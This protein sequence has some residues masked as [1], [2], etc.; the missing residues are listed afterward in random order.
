MKRKRAGRITE[1]TARFKLH[2]A[3]S[4]ISKQQYFFVGHCESNTGQ[5]YIARNLAVSAQQRTQAHFQILGVI[6][7]KIGT[8]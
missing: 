8:E 4:I 6:L 5:V 1:C 7:G 3:I 2:F